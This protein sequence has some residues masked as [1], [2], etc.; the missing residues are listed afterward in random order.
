MLSKIKSYL[1]LIAII[2]AILSGVWGI[3]SSRQATKY[4]IAR[5]NAQDELTVKTS[6]VI[7]YENE[8]GQTVTKTIEYERYIS[9]L[10]FSNDSLE[11][12]LYR[13]IKASKIREKNL[14]EAYTVSVSNKSMVEYDSVSYLTNASSEGSIQPVDTIPC[15]EVRYYND[16]FTKVISYPD[17]MLI[18]D[19]EKLTIL[20][21]SREV[22]RK[23]VVW[24]W[25][26]WKK[27]IDRNMVE[28]ISSDPKS[29]IDG[30]Y[31]IKLK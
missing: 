23:F 19:H 12:D 8:L 7:K 1:T 9:D 24:R 13:T 5:D 27:T 30:I 31:M 11:R 20:K 22:D 17:S 21:G 29:N 4:K 26:G 25:I 16:G 2:I 10:E 15:N 28:V 18:E 3:Y 6:E 14:V